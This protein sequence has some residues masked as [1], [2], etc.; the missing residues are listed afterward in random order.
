VLEIAALY[1]Y[2]LTE[3]EK[4]RIVMIITGLSAGTTT[5]ARKAGQAAAIKVGEK[6]AFKSVMKV[7]PV[8]GVVASAGTNVLSTYII[9]QRADAYFRLGP[10]A[11]GTWTDSLRA[12]SGVDERN[13]ARLIADGGKT[14]GSVIV[15]GAGKA[16][17]AGKA[18]GGAVVVGA[19][20]AAGAV[21]AG[22]K[23]AGQ[24]AQKGI[25]AYFRW[26]FQLWKKIFGFIGKVLRFIWAVITFIPRKIGGVFKRKDKQAQSQ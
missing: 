16:G 1:N 6:F 18:A 13:V 9:G 7:L 25:T 12:I 17:E 22:A 19:G 15:T 24:T 8:I 23:Y 3:E 21:G 14:T 10:E 20:K 26:L 4:Q 2:P 11:V 5:L